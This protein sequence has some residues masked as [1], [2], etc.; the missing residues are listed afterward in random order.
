M[1]FI[2]KEPGHIFLEINFTNPYP[3]IDTF[4]LQLSDSNY[5]LFNW[6][7]KIEPAKTG[8][9]FKIPF[10]SK[11]KI[12]YL[13]LLAHNPVG[14]SRASVQMQD[15][16]NNLVATTPS[17]PYQHKLSNVQISVLLFIVFIFI[18]STS[19]QVIYFNWCVEDED[20]Y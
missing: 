19:I 17:E 1:I 14:W 18:T 13:D 8:H 9:L 7:H 6:S 10:D 20:T 15:T 4:K 16:S 2:Y 5:I 3:A 12:E 11:T